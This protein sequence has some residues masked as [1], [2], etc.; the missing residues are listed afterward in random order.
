MKTLKVLLIGAECAPFVKVG[1]LAD[2]LGALPKYISRQGVNAA[3]VVP[4]YQS[5]DREQFVLEEETALNVETGVGPMLF[6]VFK[7]VDK[8]GILHY[9]LEQEKYFSRSNIYGEKDDAERFFAFSMGTLE[10]A[11][12]EKFDIL[13]AND[14]HTALVPVLVRQDGLPF[15]TVFTIHNL[16]YQGLCSRSLSGFLKLT[17]DMDA[18]IRQDDNTMNPMKGGILCADY[19]TT[20]SPTYA[21]EI[22]TPEY[23]VGLEN[24]LVQRKDRLIGILN[25]IDVEL[26]NPATDPHIYVNFTNE[27]EKK[28]ANTEALRKELNLENGPYPVIG[29]VSRFVEQKGIDLVAEALDSIVELGAQLVALGTG[30]KKYEELLFKKAGKYPNMV[31]VNITFDPVLAQ[32]I[33]AGSTHFLMPSRFEPCGLGQM[34]ALRYGSIPIV[35]RT[36]GLADT[37]FDAEKEPNGNGFVFDEPTVDGLLGAVKRAV[38]YYKDEQMHKS[39]FNRAIAS[40]VSW[41]SSA[42]AYVKL[43]EKALIS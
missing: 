27:W 28:L 2:V 31:S 9:F 14:W 4:L 20:V 41:D 11:K 21:K 7:C 22:L 39:L 8:D 3:T 26:Y 10:L 23:G 5:I 6:R 38:A 1:G 30:D 34:I 19:V 29:L 37:V 33:Y 17:P 25:G 24:V 12:R 15:K 42:K 35:R 16:A 36:G 13:H 40:D 18:L 43:Y 32:R